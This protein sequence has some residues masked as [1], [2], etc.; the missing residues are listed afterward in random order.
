MRLTKQLILSLI[1]ICASSYGIAQNNQFTGSVL[2]KVSGNGLTANSYI[3]GTNHVLS[4]SFLSRIPGLYNILD[5]CQQVVGEIDM[6]EMT[7]N[8]DAIK[9]AS[10]MPEGKTYSQ[11]LDKSEYS[12]LDSTLQTDIKISLSQ[13]ESISPVGISSLYTIN[14]YNKI[15]EGGGYSEN[16]DNHFQ[17]YARAQEKRIVA[18]ESLEQQLQFLYYSKPLQEQISDLLCITSS[19]GNLEYLKTLDQYY[20]KGDLIGL[21]RISNEN[22][23]CPLSTEER[24][25]LGKD[26][27]NNWLKVLPD[28]MRNK[29]S[30]IAVGCLHLVGEDGLLN[31][32]DEMGYHIEPI[33]MQP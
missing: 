31:R 20:Q 8:L 9:K 1:L 16:M 24:D 27:N 18:L 14:L 13:L 32:L 19:S 7:S 29:S 22:G 4:K 6:S 11:L 21:E 2:W 3:F 28:I 17:E 30:F 5:S 33:A 12:K 23:D 10:F 26:R 15:S 25:R